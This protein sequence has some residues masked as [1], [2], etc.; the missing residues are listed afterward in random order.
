MNERDR[1]E[2]E[3]ASPR[4]EVTPEM[5]AVG[6]ETFREHIIPGPSDD[7][8]EIVTRI[9]EN[10]HRASEIQ[11]ASYRC[12]SSKCLDGGNNQEPH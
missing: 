8:E 11:R 3:K 1:P 12:D 4:S 9:Y 7:V 5:I 2:T 6:V 10:M